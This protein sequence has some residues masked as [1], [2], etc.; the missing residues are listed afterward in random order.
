MQCSKNDLHGIHYN[1]RFFNTLFLTN[2]QPPPNL[3]TLAANRTIRF[4]RWIAKFLVNAPMALCSIFFLH[5]LMFVSNLVAKNVILADV[6]MNCVF[7]ITKKIEADAKIGQGHT[8]AIDIVIN[9][10]A[11]S[12]FGQNKAQQFCEMTKN[13]NNYVIT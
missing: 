2:P 1:S 8:K 13:L 6:A 5:C 7:F 4:V 12:V 3:S 11:P 10:F 9:F